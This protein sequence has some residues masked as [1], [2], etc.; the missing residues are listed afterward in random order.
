MSK[1]AVL[2]MD[3]EDWF[4]TIYFDRKLTNK[5]YSMLDGAYN[6]LEILERKKLKTTFFVVGEVG[7]KYKSLIRQISE[8]GHE[9]SCH[10]LKHFLPLTQ[11]NSQFKDDLIENKNILEDIIQKKIIGYRAPAFNLDNDKF[12]ILIENNFLYDS[13]K[14]NY[15]SKLYKRFNLK[16]F[17]KL[18][19]NIYKGNNFTEFEISTIKTLN[20]N[21]HLGGGGFFRIYPWFFI[22]KLLSNYTN[23]NNDYFFYIH[24]FELSNKFDI[25]FPSNTSFI[26]K[27]RFNIGR[28]KNKLKVEKLINF[29]SIKDY[30][31]C[32]FNEIINNQNA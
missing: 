17:K 3:L 4:H 2:S 1:R 6:F 15:K 14:I 28:V 23:S 27:K 5:D 32:S 7:L 30:K 31:F 26:N 25:P 29:L 19:H 16:N 24:P 8:S 10:S 13:S 22:K 11:T 9:I 20:Y 12:N 21:F 18:S